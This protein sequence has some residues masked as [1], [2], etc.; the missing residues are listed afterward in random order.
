MCCSRFTHSPT[1]TFQSHIHSPSRASPSHWGRLE[2]VWENC[3]ENTD[4]VLSVYLQIL[5]LGVTVQVLRHLKVSLGASPRIFP[6]FQELSQCYKPVWEHR[7]RDRKAP[8]QGVRFPLPIKYRQ[9][10]VLHGRCNVSI[11]GSPNC[12]LKCPVLTLTG[13]ELRKCVSLLTAHSTALQ[14]PHRALPNALLTKPLCIKAL[15]CS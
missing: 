14:A 4:V 2:L 5:L 8:C 6:S 10:S 7:T 15:K 13:A 11:L 3:K 1:F 12:G 9:G